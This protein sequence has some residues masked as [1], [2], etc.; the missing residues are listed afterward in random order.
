MKSI[1]KIIIGL[2]G[3]TVIGLV[4]YYVVSTG[5]DLSV[6]KKPITNPD[7]DTVATAEVIKDNLLDIIKV[8]L[9]IDG[10]EFTLTEEEGCIQI[11][12][13]IKY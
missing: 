4:T 13:M 8:A 7:Q 11:Q 12:Q 3:M 2:L 1:T 6:N 9:N 10:E 5:K